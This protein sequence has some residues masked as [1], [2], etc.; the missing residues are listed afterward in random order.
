MDKP[1]VWMISVYAQKQDGFNT[2]VSH[3]PIS[4]EAISA[5]EAKGMGYEWLEKY[6]PRSE[7]W[8]N[9][10]ANALPVYKEDEARLLA[11]GKEIA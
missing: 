1:I 5:T 4:R 8:G 7:G 9:Y 2:I 3:Y 6:K 10:S 11:E